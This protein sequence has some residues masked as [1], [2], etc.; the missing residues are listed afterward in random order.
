MIELKTL[1]KY[2]DDLLEIDK[3]PDDSS[4]NGLQVREITK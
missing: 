3:I 4:N 1:S 2:L